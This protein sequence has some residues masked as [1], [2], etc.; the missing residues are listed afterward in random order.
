LW[1]LLQPPE[2]ESFTNPVQIINGTVYLPNNTYHYWQATDVVIAWETFFEP[3]GLGPIPKEIR[4]YCCAQF[5][6]VDLLLD[7]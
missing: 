4:Y 1:L 2:A 7:E 3:A 5:A 6:G